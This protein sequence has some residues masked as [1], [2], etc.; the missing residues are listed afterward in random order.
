MPTPKPVSLPDA[1]KL[2]LLNAHA[3]VGP[4]WESLEERRWCLHCEQTF[5]GRAV[6]VYPDRSFPEGYSLACGT[7]DCDGSP[8]D[9]HEEGS[10]FQQAAEERGPWQPP[11]D[12]PPTAH[13]HAR[14]EEVEECGDYGPTLVIAPA[15]RDEA[16][17]AQ[18]ASLF[19]LLAPDGFYREPHPEFARAVCVAAKAALA[20]ALEGAL[21]AEALAAGGYFF[22]ARLEGFEADE[23]FGASERFEL[24]VESGSRGD[25][26]EEEFEQVYHVTGAPATEAALMEAIRQSL[27]AYLSAHGASGEGFTWRME[28]TSYGG[29]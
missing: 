3:I 23:E 28:I 11:D 20:R 5:T 12:R 4:T 16:Q 8:L 17:R 14:A 18:L 21:G 10:E 25:I 27:A 19:W 15:Y 22:A 26:G 6:R 13:G 24:E 2:A 9:W 29:G 7:P 1:E